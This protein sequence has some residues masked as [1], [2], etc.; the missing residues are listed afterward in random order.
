MMIFRMNVL[1]V[2]TFRFPFFFL[3]TPHKKEGTTHEP[4][5][6]SSK[7][8]PEKRCF[9]IFWYAK[10]QWYKTRDVV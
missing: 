5:G 7:T 8:I 10:D 6:C 4:L 1:S 9:L 2:I 3:I